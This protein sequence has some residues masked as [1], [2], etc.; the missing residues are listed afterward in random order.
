MELGEQD[1]ERLGER[2]FA[3]IHRHLGTVARDPIVVAGLTRQALRERIKEPLPRRPQG[4]APVMADFE[5]KIA[6]NSVRVGHPRFLAW[7]RTS[8]LAAAVFAEALAAALNQS[9]TAWDGAPAATETELL[10][11]DWLKEC[12]LYAPSAGGV[13]TSGGSMAN[14][15]CLQ[16]ACTAADPTFREQGLAGKTPHTVYLTRETH[17][18]LAKAVAM[19]G[20]GRKHIRYVAMDDGLRMSPGALKEAIA[21]DRRAGLRPLAAVFTLGSV[22]TGAC[23]PFRD[24]I[25][26]CRQFGVW[27]HVDGAYGGFTG[28]VPDKWPLLDGLDQADSLALDPHKVFI[29]FE[30]GCAL[31]RQPQHLFQAFSVQAD[32]LPNTLGGDEAPFHFRDYGPQLARSFRALKIYLAFKIYGI[33]ALA[34]AVA[35]NYRLAE[36][37]AQQVEGHPEMQLLAS[38]TLGVVVFRY[39]P[40]ERANRLIPDPSLD[41]LNTR[42]ALEVQQRGRVFLATTRVRG[43]VALRVCFVSFRTRAEDLAIIIEEV[44]EVG[45]SLGSS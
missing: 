36:Q 41:E 19:M 3:F 5:N 35:S 25:A 12:S 30:A 28:L 11:L 6:A 22:N 20:L 27:A 37:L 10:V 42:L 40:P 32:Y 14:F 18:C 8:P 4:V 24:L 7:I 13:L 29:P 38:P 9:V 44:R 1:I 43:H 15:T 16:A 17:Y 23:D 33:D 34:S 21:A 31:V 45:R 26:V 2:V 39:V